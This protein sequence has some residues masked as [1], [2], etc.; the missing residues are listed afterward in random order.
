M[1]FLSVK[2]EGRGQ[3]NTRVKDV[4]PGKA[5]AFFV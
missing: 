2:G 3:I 1:C 4:V 5:S